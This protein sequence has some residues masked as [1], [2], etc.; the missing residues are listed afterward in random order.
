MLYSE[1]NIISL[2]IYV[3][4]FV[5]TEIKRI[6]KNNRIHFRKMHNFKYCE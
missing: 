6:Y 3:Y 2:N 1:T 4:Y 5:I